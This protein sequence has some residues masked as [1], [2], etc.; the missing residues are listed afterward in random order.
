[1]GYIVLDETSEATAHLDAV[2]V[3]IKGRNG[4]FVVAYDTASE[5]LL[6]RTGVTAAWGV[7]CPVLV[8][9]HL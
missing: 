7:C 6:W 2:Q 4:T 5:A 9:V 1:M 3:K 8:P